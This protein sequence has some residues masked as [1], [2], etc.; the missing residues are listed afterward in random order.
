MPDDQ[1]RATND[2]WRKGDATPSDSSTAV[3][4]SGFVLADARG[5]GNA[6]TARDERMIRGLNLLFPGAG[7][8]LAGAVAGGWIVGL[9]F[10][11][12]ACAAV[13]YTFIAPDSVAPWARAALLGATIGAYA[14][15][16]VRLTRIF[17]DTAAR[18]ATEERRRILGDA[19]SALRE[20]DPGR[21]WTLLEPL[22]RSA[23]GD[24]L[25]AYRAAQILSAGDD[26]KAAR[27]AWRAVAKLDRHRVFQAQVEQELQRLAGAVGTSENP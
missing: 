16:Q 23:P 22:Y 21:A 7:M 9:A 14:G 10:T 11:G 27:E 24:L 17:R 5:S 18:G 12:A 13:F 1:G 6:A 19:L 20:G 2:Q 4:R 3:R 8:I 25:V 26:A 15:A